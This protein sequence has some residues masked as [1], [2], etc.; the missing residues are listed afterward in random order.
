MKINEVSMACVANLGKIQSV[1][2]TNPI[3]K[4]QPAYDSV[5]FSG[6]DGNLLN[7]NE[8]SVAAEKLKASTSGYRAPYGEDKPFNS[9]FVRTM[10]EAISE[11]ATEEGQK[12]TMVAGDTRRA[13]KENAPIIKEIFKE[14]G[15]NVFVPMLDGT[16]DGEI[17][18]VATPVLALATRHF[19]I[20]LAVLLT[21]SHNPWTDG[22]YNFLTDEGAVAT[23]TVTAPIADKMVEIAA[24]GRSMPRPFI[25]GNE[26]KFNPA[27]I[28]EN[29]I[30]KNNLID[31]EAIRNADIEIF[32]E[33]LEGTGNYYYPKLMEN[34]GIKIAKTLDTKA[35]G[36]NPVE[37]NLQN[38]ANEVVKSDKLLKVG[39]ATD[40]DSDRFGIIDEN[41]NFINANDVILLI[42]YHQIKNGGIKD[43]TIIRNHATSGRIDKLANY[44]NQKEG[45]NIQVEQTPVGFKFLGDK[46]LELEEEGK[47]VIVAGEE[48]GGLTIGGHIPEK[49]GFI[50]ISKI[51]EL[52][53]AEKKPIGQI[54]TDLNE[55]MESDYIS[56]CVNIKFDKEA[57]KNETVN[58]FNKFFNG[59]ED[60]IAGYEIDLEKTQ[61][62][63]KKLRGYK[64]NGDGV[65]IYL[66]D[67]TSILVRKSG[68]EPVMRLYIDACDEEVFDNLK[69]YLTD[70]AKDHGG[71]EK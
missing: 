56:K 12:A 7:E 50:A 13:T 71:S 20:P 44:F 51:A 18:P 63:D 69:N 29:H 64:P 39:L 4:F 8:A 45:Y 47:Q 10:T 35:M 60:E 26:I 53:A 24:R 38:L 17:S 61:M 37:E 3:L 30:I 54:L 46:I 5:S 31:F 34:N 25:S 43:G 19:D 11:I 23:D 14:N 66:K 1:K 42:A 32:Y 65:K 55:E 62:A 33:G 27:E 67:G 41:G 21:A 40:G 36:P 9:R 6:R 57:Q 68:T 52:M 48:S 15:L 49:D 70:V 58:Y 16:E 28:Y 22:G 59:D 2:N